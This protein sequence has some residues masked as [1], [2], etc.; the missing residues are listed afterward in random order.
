[1]TVRETELRGDPSGPGLGLGPRK[2]KETDESA[3]Q[4]TGPSTGAGL[5]QG[6]GLDRVSGRA[7]AAERSK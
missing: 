7:V 2:T 5:C 4:G 6:Q 3:G 1:M